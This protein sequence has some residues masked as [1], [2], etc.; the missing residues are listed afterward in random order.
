[1][2]LSVMLVDRLDDVDGD[3]HGAG[4]R[5]RGE[6][7][8]QLDVVASGTDAC[9]AVR[10]DGGSSGHGVVVTD[11]VE[12]TGGRCADASPDD[13]R[14]TGRQPA[15]A[16]PPIALSDVPDAAR[17][18]RRPPARYQVVGIGNA[19]VDVIAH[20]TD[21]FLVDHE[22]VK[23]SMTLIETDRAVELYRALGS[24]VEMS[25]GSAANT[26]CGVASFG[27]GPPT[28][29]RSATTSSAPCS[30]TTSTPSGWRSGPAPRRPT[31]RR[32]AASSSS[33]PTPSA[34]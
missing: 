12:R 20:A 22:L 29:A 1:M 34:R 21:E 28:S 17:R 18:R 11:S 8:R 23:G 25:G 30:A 19:L 9:Q 5:R 15:I 10:V 33:R 2:A 14:S 7:G 24:A 4:E 3:R 26:M 16:A 6:V 31:C 13:R 32:A 27:G